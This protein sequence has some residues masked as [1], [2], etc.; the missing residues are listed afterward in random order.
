MH[1][2]LKLVHPGSIA[3]KAG[4]SCLHL[5]GGIDETSAGLLSNSARK[6]FLTHGQIFRDI[7]EDLSTIMSCSAGPSTCSM[8]SLHSITDILAITLAYLSNQMA[9][10]I[11]YIPAIARIGTNLF[12]LD[13]EFRGAINSREESRR[14]KA[15]RS[16]RLQH[17]I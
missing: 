9:I 12:S 13:E 10:K 5:I 2:S 16:G 3:E 17:S 14:N 8:C 11:I 4:E 1:D 6:F 7:V 15:I